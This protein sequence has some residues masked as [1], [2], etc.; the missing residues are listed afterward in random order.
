M[1]KALVRAGLLCAGVVTTAIDI[2]M[3]L[4]INDMLDAIIIT[5]IACHAV[6]YRCLMTAKS[7][8]KEVI[9]SFFI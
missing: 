9:A 4:A 8:V 1:K 7:F 5:D 3:S 2:Q 6:T